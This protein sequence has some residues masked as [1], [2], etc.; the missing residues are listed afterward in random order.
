MHHPVTS[1]P[2]WL[3]WV[4]VRC[5]V[6]WYHIQGYV[7]WTKE[8]PSGCHRA[9]RWW[10]RKERLFVLT[11]GAIQHRDLHSASLTNTE[12]KAP[13]ARLSK[14]F[15]TQHLTLFSGMTEPLWHK[16]KINLSPFTNLPCVCSVWY[17]CFKWP[18]LAPGLVTPFMSRSLVPCSPAI[19]SLCCLLPLHKP[20]F[21]SLGCTVCPGLGY[22]LVLRMVYTAHL[23]LR[24]ASW[25]ALAGGCLVLGL[26]AVWKKPYCWVYSRYNSNVGAKK[27]TFS[28]SRGRG[29]ALPPL[30]YILPYLKGKNYLLTSWEVAERPLCPIGLYELH[31]ISILFSVPL[32]LCTNNKALWRAS[33][34]SRLCFHVAVVCLSLVHPSS[35]GS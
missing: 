25:Y 17:C 28:S 24:P 7:H 11:G 30:I 31:S 20:A 18:V 6:L 34:T 9:G 23:A 2:P 35:S 3:G 19:A 10:E 32:L 29:R 26:F 33:V 1:Q 5:G 8:V 12:C 22:S 13:E 27:A 21:L 15:R 16:A 14:M 4:T